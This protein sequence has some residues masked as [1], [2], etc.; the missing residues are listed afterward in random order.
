[1]GYSI[2]FFKVQHTN[3]CGKFELSNPQPICS[4]SHFPLSVPLVYPCFFS[5]HT[6]VLVKSPHYSL[7]YFF[8]RTELY[9]IKRNKKDMISWIIGWSCPCSVYFCFGQP[10]LHEQ[11]WHIFNEPEDIFPSDIGIEI[12]YL[13]ADERGF[14]LSGYIFFVEISNNITSM[15][16]GLSWNKFYLWTDVK[17][18]ILF[19]IVHQS[20][21]SSQKSDGLKRL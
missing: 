2:D 13:I 21:Y 20:F 19:L 4:Q 5:W 16:T 11:V 8:R 9:Q 18:V 10:T 1:M 7:I 12:W 14:Q 17:T 3:W 15:I 6:F